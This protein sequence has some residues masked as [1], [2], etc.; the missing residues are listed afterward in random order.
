[1]WL[2]ALAEA[3]ALPESELPLAAARYDGPP[4][5]RT[6]AEKDA[7]A[8]ARLT[9]ARAALAELGAELKIPVENLMTP[10][11]VRRV[12]WQPPDP[13]DADTVGA[14][15]TG[16]GARAWQVGLTREILATAIAEHPSEQAGT[17]TGT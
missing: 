17:D 15:L 9:Q 3:K 11:S 8:A 1:M 6:W 12:L 16:F 14:M 4:P 13:A 7:A 2:Q 10:D 5:P